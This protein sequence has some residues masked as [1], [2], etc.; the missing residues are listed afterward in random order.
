M[1]WAVRLFAKS[2]ELQWL[3]GDVTDGE[4]RAAASVAIHFGEDDAGNAE[5]FVKFVGR[6]YGILTGHGVGDEQDFDRIQSRFELL[7]LLHQ[8]LVDVEA[9][10]G[11]H[12]Q[13]I[14]AGVHGFAA[15]G[16]R[17]IERGFFFGRAGINRHFDIARND[18]Q[19][20]ARG[21]PID[22]HRD[23]LRT[24]T[25]LSQPACEFAGGRGFARALQADD[26]EDAGRIVGETQLRFMAA[27]DFDQ[28]LI[29][30]ADDLLGRRE[31]GEYFLAQD[32]LL[33]VFY[34]LFDDFEVDVGFEQ[35]DADL[36]QRRIH[37]FG[38][39]PAFAAQ[40]FKDALQF[41]GQVVEHADRS[42]SLR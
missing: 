8:L 39:E 27:E 35:G 38:G 6:F 16:L 2:H 11:I 36:A 23:Q 18:G 21:R 17:Q 13:N 25:V 5:A 4:G 24:M 20:I 3:P 15:S 14:A 37:V 29:D 42:G 10:G 33:H 22:V 26:H 19:L 32:P 40:I 7:Q 9:A 30:D 12:Q 41:F 31:R 1:R 28:F 34:Q